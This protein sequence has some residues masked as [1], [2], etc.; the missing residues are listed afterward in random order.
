MRMRKAPPAFMLLLLA[1]CGSR[2]PV[3]KGAENTAALPTI[4]KPAPSP[5][6]EPPKTSTAAA[7]SRP[8]ASAFAFPTALQGRWGLTPMDC[9]STRGDAKG[10]LIIAPDRMQFYESRALPATDVQVTG[11]AVAGTFDFT[12]EG[13]SWSKYQSLQIRSH[14]LIRTESNPTASFSYAKC[15]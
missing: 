8:T 2:S 13:Q 12:G 5:H 15:E 6:G 7:A 3:A 10:L 4:N 9:T 14:S 11:D 1:A